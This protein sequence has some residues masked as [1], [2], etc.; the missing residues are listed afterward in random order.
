MSLRW[1]AREYE[2]QRREREQNTRGKQEEKKGGKAGSGGQRRESGIVFFVVVAAEASTLS[3]E[4]MEEKEAKSEGGAQ[5]NEMKEKE[6]E[7]VKEI[8]NDEG[9][10]KVEIESEKEGN[11]VGEDGK[12]EEEGDKEKTLVEGE[13]VA[14]VT[15]PEAGK[16]TNVIEKPAVND[17]INNAKTS[18]D[19]MPAEKA[20]TEND[21]LATKENTNGISTDV[22]V[23]DQ[24]A[25][26]EKVDKDNASAAAGGT[27]AKLASP[28][29]AVKQEAGPQI[30]EASVNQQQQVAASGQRG[31]NTIFLE[32]QIGLKDQQTCK[33]SLVH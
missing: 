3:V 17:E 20:T 26:T 23:S 21:R 12:K 31:L 29:E 24:A 11:K 4:V 9:K 1:R 14:K 30:V 32:A 16:E 25:L 10:E 6:G 7:E 2:K 19:A 22:G 27:A 33:Y 28:K 18:N 8:D 15:E 13:Q 5:K